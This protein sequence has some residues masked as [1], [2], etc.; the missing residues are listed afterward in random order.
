MVHL[1]SDGDPVVNVLS[2]PSRHSD[3]MRWQL[4]LFGSGG[5]GGSGGSSISGS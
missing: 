4:T 3:H 1:F 5:G 2:R